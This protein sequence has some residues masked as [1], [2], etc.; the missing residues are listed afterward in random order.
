VTS[1]EISALKLK[2]GGSFD[3]ISDM[4]NKYYKNLT[5]ILT[6][7]VLLAFAMQ[8]SMLTMQ[9]LVGF[10]ESLC[11]NEVFIRSSDE[12][13]KLKISSNLARK[14]KFFND[15]LI[16]EEKDDHLN[17]ESTEKDPVIVSL[18]LWPN[19]NLKDYFKTADTFYQNKKIFKVEVNNIDSSLLPD[20]VELT[21]DLNNE[22]LLK[23]LVKVHWKKNIEPSLP[24][25]ISDIIE[26]KTTWNKLTE[27]LNSVSEDVQTEYLTPLINKHF[28]ELATPLIEKNI[29]TLPRPKDI[30]WDRIY[31]P[32]ISALIE[33]K[34]G[35]IIVGHQGT[36]VILIWDP[37]TDQLKNLP[38]DCPVGSLVEIDD[39]TIAF[40]TSNKINIC[41]LFDNPF[42]ISDKLIGHSNYVSTLLLLN[43]GSCDKN[44][45]SASL[46]K[47]IKIWDLKHGTV[48]KTIKGSSDSVTALLQ[49]TNNQ[50]QLVFGNSKGTIK[51][52]DIKNNKELQNL[53][54]HLKY[55]ASL[56][57]LK[58]GKL[59]SGSWDH[60]IKVWNTGTGTCLK[61]IENKS[62]YA[63]LYIGSVIA[64]ENTI[65]SA[66]DKYLKIWNPVTKKA[67]RIFDTG[68]ITNRAR[69]VPLKN[70]AIAFSAGSHVKILTPNLLKNIKGPKGALVTAALY[71]C[72]GK[73]GNVPDLKD[74]KYS[75][76]QETYEKLPEEVKTAFNK[77]ASSPVSSSYLF[78]QKRFVLAGLAAIFAATTAIIIKTG[79]FS[80]VKKSI[81]S[82]V[83]NWWGKG[84]E[85]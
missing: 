17:E 30:S 70:G 56:A 75:H 58:N 49:L 68:Q 54:G 55:I 25:C 37:I 13:Q 36:N 2:C 77:L 14:F 18:N 29:K 46:D 45:V 28:A 72:F 61:T 60:T 16:F 10:N 22:D 50:D 43:K 5:L 78:G 82:F 73:Y 39:K 34:N 6:K 81:T 80:Y 84:S 48:S 24:S 83:A 4:K 57:Q 41:P 35:K 52:W 23:K 66:S 42:V 85:D 9:S 79:V 51:I 47:T 31:E 7:S 20:Y 33:L 1:T 32:E 67:L 69:M 74:E 12:K 76:V 64:Y 21:N 8:G 53:D 40:S 15:Q 19:I 27:T 71:K 3:T 59:I 44:L 65:V 11:G 38:V 63:N 62:Y 26:N